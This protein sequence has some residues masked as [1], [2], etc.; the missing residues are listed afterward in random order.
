MKLLYITENINAVFYS[1]VVEL[2]NAIAENNFFDEIYLVV[3]LR[4]P[5]SIDKIKELNSNIYLLTFKTYPMYPFYNILTMNS[6]FKLFKSLS[7]NKSF[8]LHTRIE[9]MGSL[10]YQSYLKL[11][12]TKPNLLIDIRGAVIEEVKQYG[13]MNIVLKFFKLFNYK[14]N[15][16]KALSNA[17]YIN[18]VSN[19]LKDYIQN[20]YNIDT[21]IISVIPTVSGKNF[22]YNNEERQRVRK[23]IGLREEEILFVFSSGSSQAWQNDDEIVKILTQQGYKILML[24]KKQYE[25]PN[26]ISRFVP[27]IEVSSYLNAADIGIIIRNSD[28]VNNVASPIKFSE[29]ISCGLPIVSNRSVDIINRIIDKTSFGKIMDLP[30][31]DTN[32]INFLIKL[33][34]YQI[35]NFGRSIFSID[36]ITRNYMDIYL[37]MSEGKKHG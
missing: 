12:S 14:K 15:I 19:K 21:N 3:G 8:I 22:Y 17:T 34:R 1:Q 30:D 36:D 6:L 11:N 27:Y 35:S 13:R 2:L 23:S 9:F 24:T 32:T 20:T 4:D 37:K 29:Y 16:Q 5:S 25:N 10:A 26:V 7:I 28:V 33:N 18:T 31:I